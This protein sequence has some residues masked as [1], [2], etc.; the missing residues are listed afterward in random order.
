M[1]GGGNEVKEAFWLKENWPGDDIGCNRKYET[2]VF[3]AGEICTAEGCFCGLPATNGQE[4]DF[5]GYNTASDANA[6]HLELC[7][8]WATEAK[9]NE[10]P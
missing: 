1:H 6:G 3:K 4:L 8:I 9:Q 5:R 10:L 2:M 7:R